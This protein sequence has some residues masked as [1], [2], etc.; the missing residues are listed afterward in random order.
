ME[1]IGTLG[2]DCDRDGTIVHIAVED[3]YKGHIVISDRIKPDAEQAVSE[4]KRLGIGRTVMLTGDSRKVGEAIGSLLN[5]DETHS[6]LLHE[7]KVSELE[8]L[9]SRKNKNVT[10]VIFGDERQR[11]SGAVPGGCRNCHGRARKRGC[12]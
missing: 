8:K 9:L 10:L 11:C 1:Q 4:L 2:R 5:I 12:N 6:D 3:K 7:K